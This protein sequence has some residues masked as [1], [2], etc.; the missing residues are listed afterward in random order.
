LTGEPPAG[1]LRLLAGFDEWLL[2]WASRELVVASENARRVAPGGGIIR[3]VAIADGRV[4][5]TWRLDRRTGRVALDAFGRVARRE[6]EA[7]VAGLGAF[8]GLEL[9]L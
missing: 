5:A 8:L 2:G 4:V 7:E 3:A 9:R 1:P 6:L